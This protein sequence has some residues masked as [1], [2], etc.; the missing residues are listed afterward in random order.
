MAFRNWN[1]DGKKDGKDNYIEYQNYREQWRRGI[2]RGWI[3]SYAQLLFVG[4]GG[5]I[6]VYHESNSKGEYNDVLLL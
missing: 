1:H 5:Q 3:S 4:N 2:P 6:I